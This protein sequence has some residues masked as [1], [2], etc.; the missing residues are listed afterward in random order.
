MLQ[1]GWIIIFALGIVSMPLSVV[2]AATPMLGEEEYAGISY[3]NLQA[4]NPQLAN[5]IWH[6]TVA[7]GTLLFGISLLSTILSWKGLSQGS[8]LA[9]YSLLIL[10][11]TFLAAFLLAHFPI[12]NTSFQH[13]GLALVLQPIYY[14]G[15]AVSAKPVLSKRPETRR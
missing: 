11:V 6:D 8:S 7:F 12:G 13:I 4:T 5:I 3:R 9:W 14:I 2:I 10:G 1:A 15:L